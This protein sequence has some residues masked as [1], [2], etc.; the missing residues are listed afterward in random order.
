MVAESE[1]DKNQAITSNLVNAQIQIS[2]R[3]MWFER[4]HNYKP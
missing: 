3:H 1:K 2:G 4:K